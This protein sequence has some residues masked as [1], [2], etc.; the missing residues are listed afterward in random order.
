MMCNIGYGLLIQKWKQTYDDESIRAQDGFII[1]KE[2]PAGY[3][4]WEMVWI[5]RDQTMSWHGRPSVLIKDR[6]VDWPVVVE[7]LQLA[8]YPG[9]GQGKLEP[10]YSIC[11][12]TIA[13]WE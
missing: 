9:M 11:E 7:T 1:R 2:Y 10:G 4:K 6:T 8:T 12:E 5:N 3:Q 13:H